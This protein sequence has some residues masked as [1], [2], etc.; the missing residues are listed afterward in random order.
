MTATADAT[1]H[2]IARLPEGRCEPT[3]LAELAGLRYVPDTEA[4]IERERASEGFEYRYPDGRPVRKKAHL[5][6]IAALAIPPAWVEVWICRSADGHLQATGRDHR[7]RKQYVYH[8]R[9]GEVSNLAKFARMHAFGRALPAIRRTVQD[10]LKEE[11]PTPRKACAALVALLDHTY[12]RIGGEEYVRSNGSFGLSTLRRKHVTLEGGRAHLAFPAKGGEERSYIIDDPGLVRILRENVACRGYRIFRY[13]DQDGRL[14]NLDA[15]RVN[16]FLG[17]IAGEDFTAKD[18]RTWKASAL[19]AG[20]LFRR[21]SSGKA[22][23]DEEEART[24][25]LREAM[26]VAAQALGNTRTVC[27]TYYAHPLVIE[28]FE[29]G[30]FADAV[31]G[32]RPASRKWLDAD[33]Q[34]LLRVLRHFED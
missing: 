27:R 29:A 16:E 21:H 9:W 8:E 10:A 5:E 22:E 15:S 14:K 2:Q 1:L 3:D 25:M 19:V 30:A 12:A 18:F 23:P 13:E 34:V 7:E 33:E 24:E 17:D 32:F 4:G 31:E 6:R 28:S 20:E 26:D 11:A